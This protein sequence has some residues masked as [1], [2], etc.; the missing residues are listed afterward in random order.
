MS[1]PEVRVVVAA[2]RQLTRLALEALFQRFPHVS[3]ISGV[4]SSDE[5]IAA[6]VN[7]NPDLLVIYPNRMHLDVVDIARRLQEASCSVPLLIL[8]T[9][10]DSSA[11]SVAEAKHALQARSYG[12]VSC[13][14]ME[15]SAEVL[16]SAL[17]LMLAGFSV[18]GPEAQAAIEAGY[19]LVTEA[20]GDD[21]TPLTD[22]EKEVLKYL[23][24]G[25]T[26]KEIA[27]RLNIAV[28]TVEARL[29]GLATKLGAH[30]RVEV[31]LR[32][33]QLAGR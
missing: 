28:R 18:L 30:S 23:L 6:V 31:I 17:D 19:P 15:A 7:T 9:R 12:L 11:E 32:A 14:S 2:A 27:A 4:G 25:R 13:F 24:E 16:Q 5:T 1:Q 22:K 33:M 20:Y 29:A 8:T 21:T 10:H 26:N 3:V